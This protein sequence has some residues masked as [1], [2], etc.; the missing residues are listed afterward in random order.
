MLTI[1][2]E[3]RGRPRTVAAIAMV[4]LLCIAGAASLWGWGALGGRAKHAHVPDGKQIAV[5][6]EKQAR[7]RYAA[8]GA[9]VDQ[10]EAILIAQDCLRARGLREPNRSRWD[11]EISDGI[12]CVFEE[13]QPPVPGGHTVVMIARSGKVVDVQGGE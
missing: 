11:A 7:E 5:I 8:T 9:L 10:E 12:W 2:A 13:R 3:I 4:I 1:F 6:N